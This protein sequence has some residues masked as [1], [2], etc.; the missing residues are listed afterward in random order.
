[1]ANSIFLTFIQL[2]KVHHFSKSLSKFIW[3]TSKAALFSNIFPIF[4]HSSF[5]KSNS[6]IMSKL[7]PLVN[8]PIMEQ[9]PLIGLFGVHCFYFYQ[10][11]KSY[12]VW[13]EALNSALLLVVYQGQSSTQCHY[14]SLLS[15]MSEQHFHSIHQFLQLQ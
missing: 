1:M 10:K 13:Y 15:P 9:L 3:V 11:R 4:F 6:R 14:K 12:P 8:P 5:L 7:F 2:Q